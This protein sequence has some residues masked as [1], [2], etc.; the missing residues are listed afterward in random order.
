MNFEMIGRIIQIDPTQ[1]VGASG[2]KKRE[3]IIET[4]EQYPQKLKFEM[5]QEKCGLLDNKKVGDMLKVSFNIRGSEWQNKFYVNLQAWRIDK[6]TSED[7]DSEETGDYE[8]KTY[9]TGDELPF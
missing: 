5:K 9:D 3:F 2:F 6:V 1:T 8:Y 7:N 4:D